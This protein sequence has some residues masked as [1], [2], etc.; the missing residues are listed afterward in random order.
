M[1]DWGNTTRKGFTPVPRLF[2]NNYVAMGITCGEA[3]CVIHI[4]D[5]SWDGSKPFPKIAT[6]AD[7]MGLSEATVRSYVRNLRNNGFL[8]THNRKG[9]S[10][11]YDFSPLFE[12]LKA[13]I[14]EAGGDTQVF[15]N[16]PTKV[17]IELLDA[18]AQDD[19][20]KV[21]EA[22]IDEEVNKRVQAKIRQRADEKAEQTLPENKGTLS[23]NKES[24]PEPELA[25]AP[26]KPLSVTETYNESPKN[27]NSPYRR[28]RSKTKA[29]KDLSVPD[30]LARAQMTDASQLP[31]G[32]ENRN[33]QTAK[34]AK[35][36][37]RVRKFLSKDP[38]EYHSNDME[39]VFRTAWKATEWKSPPSSFTGK[40]RGLA[41]KLIEQF[42][43]A[44][45]AEVI[46]ATI[47][48]WGRIKEEFPQLNGY[49]SVGMIFGFRSSLFPLVLEGDLD[50]AA[51]GPSWGSHA[52]DGKQTPEGEESGWFGVDLD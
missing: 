14:E 27:S 52:P 38:S 46:K 13:C 51:K 37:K 20:E 29:L 22:A 8:K 47:V 34:M 30:L 50:K 41:K 24:P 5:Y 16:L 40:D 4:L 23:E 18:S 7:K 25:K 33:G 3:M 11:A 31:S 43:A 39:L 35:R 6:V 2:L 1:L 45:T 44:N 32:S 9:R 36:N 19:L 17:V 28:I 10:N 26:E 49:P 21:Q 48:Q 42:G 15:E 12:R